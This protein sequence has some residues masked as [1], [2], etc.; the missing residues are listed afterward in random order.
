MHILA[1][2][3]SRVIALAAWR[4]I[5]LVKQIVVIRDVVEAE[6]IKFL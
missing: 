4:K 1:K 3:K 5:A 6:A 2:I